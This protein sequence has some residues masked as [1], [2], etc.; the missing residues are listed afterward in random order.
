MTLASRN[1]GRLAASALCIVLS[2][3]S[4]ACDLEVDSHYGP[5]S[6]LLKSNLPNPT[7]TAG[8]GGFPC[9]TPV[10]GGACSVSYSA[11]IWPKMSTTWHCSDPTCHGATANQPFNIDNATD[12]YNNLMAFQ[13]SGKPYLNPCSTDPDASAF[14]CNIQ[15]PACGT[16]QMPLTN[17]TVGSGPM[18]SSDVALVQTWVQCGAPKN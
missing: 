17:A 1:I 15:S 5:H 2:E 6:G 11:Q 16:G 12:A 13:I 3:F 8:D 10:D 7:P 18:S 4:G 9:G 14:V